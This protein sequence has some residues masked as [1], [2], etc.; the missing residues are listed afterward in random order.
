MGKMV[1]APAIVDM[2]DLVRNVIDAAQVDAKRK[3]QQLLSTLESAPMF[4]DPV[5]IEQIVWN[6][7]ANAIKFTPDGGTV[8]VQLAVENF[9]VQLTVEDSGVGI[10][11]EH[12]AHV[13]EMFHRGDPATA[14]GVHGLGIGLALVKQLVQLHK[15]TVEASSPGPGRGATFKV[16]LPQAVGD[17]GMAAG[18]HTRSALDGLSLLVVD[19]DDE[20][21]GVFADILRQD[22]ATVETAASA[23]AA[24]ER[25][26]ASRFDA[27]ISDVRM[28]G[29][30]GFW[31][32]SKLRASRATKDLP[33]VAMS[34]M[35]READEA[36]A[37]AAGFHGLVGKPVDSER[38]KDIILSVLQARR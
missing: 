2:A 22:G 36:Q 20:F 9:V 10:P 14:R 34:V 16:T 38:L 12:L 33:L 25:A 37:M 13:F 17:A 35:A 32:A 5:R 29:H 30:D 21:L 15:G 24:L 27:L 1:L 28:P 11:P 18:E 26:H 31:L 19:D 4:V 8:R 23:D 6:L 3:G 7:V